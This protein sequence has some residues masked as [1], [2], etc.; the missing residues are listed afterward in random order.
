MVNQNLPGLKKTVHRSNL[1]S[2]IQNEGKIKCQSSKNKINSDP[3]LYFQEKEKEENFIAPINSKTKFINPNFISFSS[4]TA[5][6]KQWAQKIQNRINPSLGQRNPNPYLVKK[7]GTILK[8]SN[9]LKNNQK[10]DKTS[11]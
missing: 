1:F 11:N 6:I 2:K 5:E 7:R 10:I 3:Y 8:Q 9:W 4:S